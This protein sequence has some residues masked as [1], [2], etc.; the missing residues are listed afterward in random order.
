M[1]LTD[2]QG[3]ITAHSARPWASITFSGTQHAIT[4]DFEGADAV[5]AGE[6]FIARLEDHEFNIPGQIV[7]DAAI[8]AV[9]HVRGMPALIVHAEILMLAEE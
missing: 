4:L 1:L 6:G 3:E 7:A 8:K 2:Q 5:Q 9:E